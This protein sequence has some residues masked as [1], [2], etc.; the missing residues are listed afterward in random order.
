MSRPLTKVFY[1]RKKNKKKSYRNSQTQP[2]P[3]FANL[4]LSKR[5]LGAARTIQGEM[6][7]T[8]M[9]LS[10]QVPPPIVFNLPKKSSVWTLEV[11]NHPFG[12]NRPNLRRGSTKQPSLPCGTWLSSPNVFC[13]LPRQAGRGKGCLIGMSNNRL[14][15]PPKKKTATK[16]T[17]QKK[18]LVFFVRMLKREND[19]PSRN[20]CHEDNFVTVSQCFS[21][22]NFVDLSPHKH[23][24]VPGLLEP[25]T[26]VQKNGCGAS[27][28]LSS[29]ATFA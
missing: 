4:V 27:T 12:M 14:Y 23:P 20:G 16:F 5:V 29:N 18:R 15:P 9:F 10:K 17:I 28:L 8:G 13:L 22:F 1:K 19:F 3:I 2:P 6:Y 7:K 25:A 21:K 24:A 11:P 26:H